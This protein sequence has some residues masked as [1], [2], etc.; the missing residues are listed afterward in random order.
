MAV[1]IGADYAIYVIYRLRE[2]HA[3]LGDPPAAT[4]AALATSGKAVLF[5]AAAISAGY[6]AL[7]ASDFY[8]NRILAEL[9]PVTMI[10]SCLAAVTVMPAALLHARPKFLFGKVETGVGTPFR[11]PSGRAAEAAPVPVELTRRALP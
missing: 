1:G 7:G 4:A 2:E 5:V 10:V 6:A 3:R 9:V 11:D 8:V